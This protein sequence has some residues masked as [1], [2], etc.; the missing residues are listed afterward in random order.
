MNELCPIDKTRQSY[1]VILCV[2]TLAVMLF[3][4]ESVDVIHRQVWVKKNST[5]GEG[6]GWM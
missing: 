3:L 2:L 4:R 6:V 5:G 1:K